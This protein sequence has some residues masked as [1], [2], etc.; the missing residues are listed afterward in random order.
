DYRRA[1]YRLP[2]AGIRPSLARDGADGWIAEKLAEH[3]ALL[4]SV[5][6]R[7]EMLRARRVRLRRQTDGD[8]VDLDA[9]IEHRADV[10]AGCCGS[11]GL[12]ETRRPV[13]RD[14]AVLLLIDVSG[15]TDA[16]IETERRVIDV[17]REAL[18]I[19]SAALESLGE[20]FAIEAFSGEGPDRVHLRT[21]KRF[22][23]PYGRGV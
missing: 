12:Y 23:E 8:E 15:S 22:D 6:R 9:C 14:L 16:W 13:N 17:E 1:E 18:L 2:G 11:D 5:Q 20:P 21:V 3:A 19:V 4:E 10:A 7:F